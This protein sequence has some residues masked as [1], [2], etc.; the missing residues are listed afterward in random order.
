MPEETKGSRF[1]TVVVLVFVLFMAFLGIYRFFSPD[2]WSLD[3]PVNEDVI[4]TEYATNVDG[5][6]VYIELIEGGTE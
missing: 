2:N 3:D 4:A 1:L 6:T 5:E